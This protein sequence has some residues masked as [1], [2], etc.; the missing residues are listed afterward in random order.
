MRRF[1]LAT[2]VFL[3]ALSS[4]EAQVF[5][6]EKAAGWTVI[7]HSAGNFT[8]SDSMT[9]TVEEGDIASRGFMYT[10]SGSVVVVVFWLGNTSIGGTPSSELRIGLPAGLTPTNNTQNVCSVANGGVAGTGQVRA[11][12]G[13]TYLSVYKADGS[14][15]ATSTNATNIQGMIMFEA[16]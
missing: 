9:W 11:L 16:R 12:S 15:W 6:T 4:A 1:L 14:N 2:A 10:R 8:A 7:P 3:L 13:Q 5:E